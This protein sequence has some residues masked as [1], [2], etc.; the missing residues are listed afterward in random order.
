MEAPDDTIIRL[1]AE[2]ATALLDSVEAVDQRAEALSAE[3]QAARLAER[4]ERGRQALAQILD[5]LR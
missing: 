3:A 2:D 1:N 4:R 5:V